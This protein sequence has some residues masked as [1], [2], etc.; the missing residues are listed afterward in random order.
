MMRGALGFLV[1]LKV[2]VSGVEAR[3]L[4]LTTARCTKQRKKTGLCSLR[5]VALW[6]P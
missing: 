6:D 5:E 2:L 4:I 1:P 3:Q